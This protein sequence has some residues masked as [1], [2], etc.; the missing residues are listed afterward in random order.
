[1][2]FTITVVT[3]CKSEVKAQPRPTRRYS[4]QQ[5]TN[6]SEWFPGLDII[7]FLERELVF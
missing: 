5:N 2:K 6:T 3:G 7:S 4:G 1:M